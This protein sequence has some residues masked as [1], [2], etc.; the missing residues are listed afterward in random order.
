MALYV[1]LLPMYVGMIHRRLWHCCNWSKE[2]GYQPWAI[3]NFSIFQAPNELEFCWFVHVYVQVLKTLFF[4]LHNTSIARRTRLWTLLLVDTDG[5][6][7]THLPCLDFSVPTFLLIDTG[8]S[9]NWQ[10][11]N[12][13]H[14]FHACELLYQT[15]QGRTSGDMSYTVV[16]PCHFFFFACPYLYKHA[17]VDTYLFTS[18]L[19]TAIMSASATTFID[20]SDWTHTSTWCFWPLESFKVSFLHGCAWYAGTTTPVP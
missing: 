20:P 11:G 2:F 13:K 14:E 7:S 1:H 17:N 5:Y 4:V 15:S 19:G 8:T 9:Y 10:K 6:D 12:C 3:Q 18:S 16:H